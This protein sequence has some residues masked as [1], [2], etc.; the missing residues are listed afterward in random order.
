MT[1][2]AA[3]LDNRRSFHASIRRLMGSKLR[4]IQSAPM[5]NESSMGKFLKCFTRTGVN[6]PGTVFPELLD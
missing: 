3:G 5:A 6:R 2:I 4:W 1:R